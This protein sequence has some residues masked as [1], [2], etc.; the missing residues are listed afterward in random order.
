MAMKISFDLAVRDFIAKYCDE[1]S[2]DTQLQYVRRVRKPREPQMSVRDFQMYSEN[3]NQVA[4][5]MPGTSPILTD[6]ELKRALVQAMPDTWQTAFSQAGRTVTGCTLLECISYF[7]QVET[8]A[9]HIAQLNQQRQRNQPYQ[10]KRSR[11]MRTEVADGSGDES[12]E[13]DDDA[14]MNQQRQG[15][16]R[17][18][19]HRHYSSASQK[20]PDN[21]MLQLEDSCLVHRHL[22]DKNHAWKDCVVRKAYVA[23]QE[24]SKKVPIIIKNS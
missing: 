18:R 4:D 10:R 21:S 20:R 13:D 14:T 24:A 16:D 23:Q 15:N 9:N 22:G 6:D 8:S 2:R 17:S 12:T 3:C 11:K 19:L 1:S 5:W 7:E